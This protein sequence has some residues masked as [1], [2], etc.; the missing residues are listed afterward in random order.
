M[1]L[2]RPALALAVA[3]C[4]VLAGG[5][6][7][8]EAEVT[9][10]VAY[11]GAPAVVLHSVDG[12]V[13]LDAF[14]GRPVVVHLAASGEAAAWA[15][16]AEVSDDLEASGAV[17]VAVVVDGPG[18]EATAAMGYRGAP[19]AV[20]VDGEGTVRGHVA[21]TSGDAVFEAAV[22]VLA[23]YDLSQSVAWPGADTLDDLVRAGGVVVDLG[24]ASAPPNALALDADVLAADDLPADLG[25]PLAFVGPDADRTAERAAGWGY[26]AAYA[27]AE[28]GRL[29][30]AAPPP[31]RPAVAGGV[32]G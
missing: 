9:A 2:P 6:G 14:A 8:G 7:A 15:V 23:E 32:R 3:L 21:P 10:V 25:T 1:P 19:L 13:S 5:C 30:P 17:V 28:D 4:S 12:P 26:A 16:L 27:V 11:G 29:V 18:D 31:P 20:V 24:A 22:P